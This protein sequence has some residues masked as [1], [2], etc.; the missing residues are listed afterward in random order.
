MGF[1]LG[2]MG[3]TLRMNRKANYWGG[4]WVTGFFEKVV[5]LDRAWI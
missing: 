1:Y 3:E 2:G 5:M 4:N